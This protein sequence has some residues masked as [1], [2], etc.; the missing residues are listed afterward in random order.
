MFHKSLLHA[1]SQ[2]PHP[3]VYSAPHPAGSSHSP[4]LMYEV[5]LDWIT[6]DRVILPL[7]TFSAFTLLFLCL[8]FCPN[9]L[10]A[11]LLFSVLLSLYF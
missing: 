1:S 7:L 3:H 2:D 5:V 4:G 11:S 6:S 9:W 10:H 8:S